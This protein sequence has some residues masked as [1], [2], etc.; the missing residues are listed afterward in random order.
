MF[1]FFKKIESGEL[2]RVGR[3]D[4]NGDVEYYR[5]LSRLGPQTLGGLANDSDVFLAE[6]ERDGLEYVLKGVDY[7]NTRLDNPNQVAKGVSVFLQATHPH[8]A[9]LF[10]WFEREDLQGGWMVMEY[11][12]GES[13]GIYLRKDVFDIGVIIDVTVALVQALDSL[14]T[15]NAYYR[16]L[17]PEHLIINVKN[18]K[19]ETKL[20]G[21]S[22][23][24]Q[25]NDSGMVE[26]VG[27]ENRL[28]PE[29]GELIE[30]GA[31]GVWLLGVLVYEGLFHLDVFCCLI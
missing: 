17:R 28:P 20:V 12:R 10:Y 22:L 14:H 23:S 27:T 16:D 4:E 11:V 29:G 18:G 31:F 26:R 21:F 1:S 30:G 9:K 7:G 5:L 25:G 2:G 3:V 19:L 13:F 6:S 8:I 15:K 24:C